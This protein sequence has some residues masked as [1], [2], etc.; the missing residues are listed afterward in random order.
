MP[1]T[2]LLLTASAFC[3]LS[4]IAAPAIAGAPAPVDAESKAGK[5]ALLDEKVVTVRNVSRAELVNGLPLVD[6]DGVAIGTVQRLA[7]NEVIVSDGTAEYR[8][9][10]TQV[11]AF[12]KDGADHYAS[13][14][15]K[16]RLTPEPIAAPAPAPQPQADDDWEALGPE[17]GPLPDDEEAEP[18]VPDTAPAEAPADTAAAP[19]T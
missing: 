3:A 19:G 12:S 14:T 1:R 17:G 9:P 7:G 16:K 13:R 4:F 2:M 5:R 11:Y 6:D 15:P 8:V 10:F 18:A